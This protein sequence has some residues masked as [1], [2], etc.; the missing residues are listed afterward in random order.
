MSVKELQIKGSTESPDILSSD[1]I[2]LIQINY[3]SLCIQENILQT[4]L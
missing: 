4:T 2:S 3:R 1:M